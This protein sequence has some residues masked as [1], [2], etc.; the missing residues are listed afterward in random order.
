MTIYDC[1][2]LYNEVDM[3]E[4]RMHVLRDVVDVFVVCE[5]NMTHSGDT[6]PLHFLRHH[7]RFA[8]FNVQYVTADLSTYADNWE[9][10]RGQRRQI[11]RG[12]RYAQEGDTVIVADVDEI[13]RPE[14]IRDFA[15]STHASARFELDMYY[16]N[17]NTRVVQGWSIGAVKWMHHLDPNDVRALTEGHAYDN[18]GWHFSYFGGPDQIRNKL[19]H[20]L[21]HD[22]V[23]PDM[24]VA[25]QVE[26][27]IASGVD[28]WQRDNVRLA[29]T[30]DT[31]TLPAYLLTNREHYEGWF[32]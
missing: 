18:A 13:P 22:W 17:V 25:G 5:S 15:R 24:M 2:M 19:T 23:K 14:L 3:L 20:F 8:D 6:K 12:L 9:R 7:D 31:S 32:A 1:T 11:A 21:H 29:H 16:Y 27:A 10:E 28:L 26:R 4:F 30:D